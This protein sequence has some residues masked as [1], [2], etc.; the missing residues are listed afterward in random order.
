MSSYSLNNALEEVYR[1]TTTGYSNR[2]GLDW[3]GSYRKTFAKKD[4]EWSVAFELDMDDD[5]SESQ[6]N[7][8]YA[9]PET[10]SD[11]LDDNND[12]GDNLEFTIQTDYIH[13]IHEMFSYRRGEITLRKLK[14]ISATSDNPTNDWVLDRHVRYLL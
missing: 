4:Q 5:V 10:Q 3:E 12:V 9:V 7:V 14:V 8:I 13:P 1:R 6:Y 11:E 2:S